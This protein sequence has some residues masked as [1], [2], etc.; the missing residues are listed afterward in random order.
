MKHTLL[1]AES[2]IQKDSQADRPRQA[3]DKYRH[4]EHGARMSNLRNVQTTATANTIAETRHTTTVVADRVNR[5]DA[6]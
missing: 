4:R 2:N 5:F 6:F 1:I 3:R